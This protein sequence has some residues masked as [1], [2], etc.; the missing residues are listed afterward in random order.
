MP[1]VQR[2]RSGSAE[3]ASGWRAPG[4]HGTRV[5]IFV[6]VPFGSHLRLKCHSTSCKMSHNRVRKLS[7][8]LT[9]CGRC[10]HT[11]RSD[12]RWIVLVEAGRSEMCSQVRARLTTEALCVWAACG[13]GPSVPGA[14]PLEDRP[15]PC[16]L[17]RPV[18]ISRSVGGRAASGWRAGGRFEK[19]K[20]ENKRGPGGPPPPL[21]VENTCKGAKEGGLDAGGGA[22][23]QHQVRAGRMALRVGFDL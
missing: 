6:L 9:A 8:C 1:H 16:A 23:K 21:G 10:A 20:T 14:A 12:A 11:E 22:G 15:P 19:Q 7:L 13:G 18:L 17:G 4:S 2:R 3:H 5:P